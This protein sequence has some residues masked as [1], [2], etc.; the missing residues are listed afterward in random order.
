MILML[1]FFPFLLIIFILQWPR[2][3]NERNDSTQI[4]INCGFIPSSLHCYYIHI[5]VFV[6]FEYSFCFFFIL[7]VTNDSWF[8]T[9]YFPFH[10]IFIRVPVYYFLF[11]LHLHPLLLILEAKVAFCC[12]CEINGKYYNLDEA[13][14]V[15]WG[16]DFW[17]ISL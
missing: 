14:I 4:I 13:T 15:L 11:L 10:F 8:Y 9:F 7:S 6:Y 17:A 3:I 5:H 2:E 1:P 12:C 16:S